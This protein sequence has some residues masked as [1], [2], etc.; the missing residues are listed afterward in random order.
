M[1]DLDI[2]RNKFNSQQREILAIIWQFYVKESHWMPARLLHVT[3]GGKKVVRSVLEQFG[4]SIVYEQEE[5][6][7]PHYGL[8]FLGVLLSSEGEYIE[9]LIANYLRLAQTLAL[10]EPHRTHVSSQEALTHLRL[11][12]KGVIELGRFLFLSPFLWNGS[13][14]P[15][16]WNA[17]LPK[18][19]EDLPDD[20]HKYIHERAAEQY[21]SDAP[22]SPAA[23]RVGIQML[24]EK[25]NSN[26]FVDELRMDQ[27]SHINSQNYDLTRLVELCKE[28]NIRYSK[29]SYLAVAM[30]TR[31]LL[32]HIPPIFGVS[33]FSEVAN[34][35]NGSRSFKESMQ[36]L[37]T[38]CRKIADSH[39][40]IA[41]RKKEVLPTKTQVNFTND[42]DVL[43]AE[44]VRLLG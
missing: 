1:E 12:Q 14:S 24:V 30:L 2:L 42:V 26:T 44:I 38:S 4:G 39:L 34:N 20:L 22:V 29:E 18:D 13:F 3:N 35:Y 23:K 28:L 10:Q 43:L 40:H 16:E 17:G 21:D 19:I 31:S 41:I 11:D 36:R 9:E 37:D 7:I 15:S 27:L 8:T 25:Q 5:K 33:T 6:G 32:D